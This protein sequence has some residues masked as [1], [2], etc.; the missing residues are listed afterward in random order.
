M[1]A[2]AITDDRYQGI[3][4]ISSIG[5]SLS[6]LKKVHLHYRMIRSVCDVI[7]Q[8]YPHSKIERRYIAYDEHGTSQRAA[9]LENARC[10]VHLKSKIDNGRIHNWSIELNP[11]CTILRPGLL[12]PA[13]KALSYIMSVTWRV[14]QATVSSFKI[15][16]KRYFTHI[17]YKTLSLT[18][19]FSFL[20][21]NCDRCHSD[22]DVKT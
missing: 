7:N 13:R 1:K 9:R 15:T 16:D 11:A 17:A 6:K 21:A 18:L 12:V 4:C 20:F 8:V 5:H 2:L 3:R 22:C 19:D 10:G 14:D